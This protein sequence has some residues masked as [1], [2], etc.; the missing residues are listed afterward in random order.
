[1][2]VS[3]KE[4][5][6]FYYFIDKIA[7]FHGHVCVGIAMGTK[8]ALAAMRV[9]GFDPYV[10]KHKDLIVYVE[11]DRCMTDAVQGVTGCGLGKR[12]L[13]HVDYGKFAATFVKLST[14]EAYR[15]TTT[16]DFDKNLS[17]DEVLKIVSETPDEEML[18]LERVKVDIPENDLP[19][20]AKARAVCTKCGE[21]VMDGRAVFEDD[22]PYCKACLYG[23]YYKTQE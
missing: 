17:V 16:K 3:A 2:A 8:S 11:T 9:L 21:R 5:E 12:S 10:K 6:D 14:G 15:V 7:E 22:K 19:G 23:A 1:M 4:I 18:K 13:K 20:A